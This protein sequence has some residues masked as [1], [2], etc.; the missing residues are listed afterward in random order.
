MCTYNTSAYPCYC[1]GTINPQHT[2]TPSLCHLILFCGQ[3]CPP[4][5]L[6][7]CTVG[8]VGH[9][10]HTHITQRLVGS[11]RHL[12]WEECCRITCWYHKFHA[13][14][15]VGFVNEVNGP[16]QGAAAGFI[17]PLTI[18]LICK[19]IVCMYAMRRK[20]GGRDNVLETYI[21]QPQQ[22][23]YYVHQLS[24]HHQHTWLTCGA[25]DMG[26]RGIA[27]STFCKSNAAC[28]SY[29]ILT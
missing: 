3:Y 15:G 6:G 11:E 13:A 28:D 19:D 18:N 1:L 10:S 17:S 16:Q 23:S 7:R 12:H 22:S 29:S 25:W 27:I 2:P 4:S 8:E 21:V 5:K 24:S 20:I 9:G 26:G 14:T